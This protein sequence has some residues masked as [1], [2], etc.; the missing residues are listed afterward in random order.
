MGDF[1]GFDSFRFILGFNSTCEGCCVHN[2]TAV[3]MCGRSESLFV[4][5][6]GSSMDKSD[7]LLYEMVIKEAMEGLS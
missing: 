5:S 6:V 7:N 4:P 1:F 2:R 3:L